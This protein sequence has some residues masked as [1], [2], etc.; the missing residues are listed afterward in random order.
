MTLWS[1]L[2]GLV[3]SKP[4]AT[5]EDLK[6]FIESRA[7]YLVQKSI[8]EYCQARANMLFTTLLGEKAFLAAYEH[9]RWHGY[10]AAYS[11]VTEM[12]EGIL[13]PHAEGHLVQLH[14]GLLAIARDVFDGFPLPEGASPQFWMEAEARLDRDLGAASLGAPKPV[15]AIPL[16]RA[17]EIFDV[18]PVHERLR[19]HDFDM[20]RNT[21]RFHLTETGVEFEERADPASLARILVVPP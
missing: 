17:R 9:A 11:M 1:T 7:A 15:H 2:K 3:G 10:P 4:V 20:F 5:R 8:M 21:L 19:A 12:V 18:L 6:R 16:A 14:A 13:R